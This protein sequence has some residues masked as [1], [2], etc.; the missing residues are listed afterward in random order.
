MAK[1]NVAMETYMLKCSMFAFIQISTL[2]ILP[3]FKF[4]S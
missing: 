2:N 3:P 4:V 1:L